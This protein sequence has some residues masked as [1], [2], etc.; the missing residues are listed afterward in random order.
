[1]RQESNSPSHSVVFSAINARMEIM[2]EP[3]LPGFCGFI[4]Y[5][6]SRDL[7]RPLG[8]PRGLKGLL[9]MPNAT[10]ITYGS[11]TRSWNF[12]YRAAEKKTENGGKGAG[13]PAPFPERELQFS[14]LFWRSFDSQPSPEAQLYNI[15]FRIE[16]RKR[17]KDRER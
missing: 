13:A 4:F 2:E 9:H 15:L 5:R 10:V 17:R 3:R 16:K 1:M 6:P 12:V 7:T 11:G 14:I 8:R